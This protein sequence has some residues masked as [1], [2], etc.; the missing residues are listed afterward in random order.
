[1]TTGVE[2]GKLWIQTCWVLLKNDL[3]MDPVYVYM[4]GKYVINGINVWYS[5]Q[6]EEKKQPNMFL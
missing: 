5:K 4:L 6:A 3:A 1:M 2:E